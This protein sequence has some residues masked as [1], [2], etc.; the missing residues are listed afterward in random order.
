MFSSRAGGDPN[1]RLK[2]VDQRQMCLSRRVLDPFLYHEY[3]FSHL[4]HICRRNW[5]GVKAHQGVSFQKTL[6]FDGERKLAKCVATSFTGP[7]CIGACHGRHA[8]VRTFTRPHNVTF[9]ERTLEDV[10]RD[11]YHLEEVLSQKTAT[12]NQLLMDRF[13]GGMLQK[14]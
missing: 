2:E 5:P 1:D 12:T 6:S 7:L 13:S 14:F 4:P 8:K 9:I 10:T 11:I 3:L